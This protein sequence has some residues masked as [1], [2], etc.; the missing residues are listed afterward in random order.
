ELYQPRARPFP[1]SACAGSL[2]G[3]MAAS[4]AAVVARGP[5]SCAG[6]DGG[7]VTAAGELRELAGRLATQQQGG[8]RR[9][10][11]PQPRGG[12][13]GPTGAGGEVALPSYCDRKRCL[14]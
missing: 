9:R 12:A 6:G 2:L 4:T 10:D 5:Q 1:Q 11:I 8:A 14:F 7:G 3:F 13:C